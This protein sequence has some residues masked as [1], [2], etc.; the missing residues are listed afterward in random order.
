MTIQDKI[1]AAAEEICTDNCPWESDT[2]EYNFGHDMFNEGAKFA[3]E[4]MAGEIDLIKT[5]YNE[6]LEPLFIVKLDKLRADLQIAIKT[7]EKLPCRKELASAYSVCCLRCDALAK[8]KG[9]SDELE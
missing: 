6:V 9:G 1:K 3:R 2:E 4:L 5:E 7:L 8:I